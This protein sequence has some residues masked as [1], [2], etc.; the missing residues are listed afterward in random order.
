[1]TPSLTTRAF[2]LLKRITRHVP[3]AVF[4]ADGFVVFELPPV[5]EAP[6]PGV[7]GVELGR[8]DLPRLAACRAMRD[9]A[10]GVRV[11]ARRLEQG[12]RVFGL[13]EAGEVLGFSWGRVGAY[14]PEDRDRY[15]MD[16]APTD[17]YLFDA[18]MHPWARGRGLFELLAAT[19][20]SGLA[21]QG[22]RRFV[23]T[24]GLSNAVSLRV[25]ERV[26]S[27]RLEVV[28][29]LHLPGLTLH[30]S[31]SALGTRVQAGDRDFVSRAPRDPGAA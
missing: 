15:R 2:G 25:H 18:W 31:R 30:G 21:D 3:P 8:E 7:A 14:V 16:L 4:E 11:F 6:V 28:G 20:Q 13:V 10:A 5:A 29:Y 17:A 22:A 27:Q 19:I 1:M 23:S 12:A 9:P 24:V 26:G